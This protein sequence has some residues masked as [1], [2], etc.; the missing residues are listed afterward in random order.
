[1]FTQTALLP[2]TNA[3]IKLSSHILASRPPSSSHIAFPGYPHRTDLDVLYRPVR[4]SSTLSPEDIMSLRDLHADLI[5]I[6]TRAKE[7]GVKVVV[8]AEYRF[9]L[10]HICILMF[11]LTFNISWYQPALD[12][13]TLSLMRQFNKLSPNGP[14]DRSEIQPLVYGTYQAYLRR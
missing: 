9:V 3:L 5:R 1:M 14:N 7:R 13:L 2:N 6:C 11:R 12:A 4:G 10:N 8:D